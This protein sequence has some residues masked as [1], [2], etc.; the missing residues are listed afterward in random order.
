MTAVQSDQDLRSSREPATRLTRRRRV[1]GFRFAAGSS[2]VEATRHGARRSTR[3]RCAPLK[4]AR[5]QNP[6]EVL[7]CCRDGTYLVWGRGVGVPPKRN[8]ELIGN[9]GQAAS[10][11]SRDWASTRGP[12]GLGWRP[13]PVTTWC[14]SLRLSTRG[15]PGCW[16]SFGCVSS[17]WEPLRSDR[18]VS[19]IAT[20]R[21]H[22]SKA[23]KE[24]FSP[25]A[26]R[27]G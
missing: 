11:E 15:R 10:A 20:S 7:H 9:G 3:W 23:P 27:V 26:C 19:R 22:P 18:R 2:A 24:K 13:A 4:R 1:R 14:S 6:P 21:A 16:R 8:A 25:L 12:R 5:G 17:S